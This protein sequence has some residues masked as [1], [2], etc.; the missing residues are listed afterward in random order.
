MYQIMMR[1]PKAGLNWLRSWVPYC[2]AVH[3]YEE[4]ERDLNDILA[5]DEHY[6]V[7]GW[8]YEIREVKRK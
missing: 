1:R 7:T 6:G 5:Y 2:S 8:D 3:T 4:A